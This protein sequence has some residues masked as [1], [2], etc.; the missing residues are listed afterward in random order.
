MA[1]VVLASA[2]GSPGVTTTALGLALR[3]PRP[4]VLVDGDPVGGSA[5]LAGF[6]RGQVAHN[7]GLVQLVLAGRA[8]ELAE[9][10][11]TVLMPLPNSNAALLPG[12]RSHAQAA[13]ATE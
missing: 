10:L 3:W 7:D 9:V 1:L 5:V 12:P 13:S 8:G 2:S 6:F 11:P 4:V